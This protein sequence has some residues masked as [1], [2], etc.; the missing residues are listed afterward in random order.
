MNRLETA[1]DLLIVCTPLIIFSITMFLSTIFETEQA[2]RYNKITKK[3]LDPTLKWSQIME[4]VNISAING[5]YDMLI[6][7]TEISDKHIKKLRRR[8]FKIRY[9]EDQKVIIIS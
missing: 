9:P 5:E 4:K 8:G 2:E 6:H 1:V 3:S 7:K